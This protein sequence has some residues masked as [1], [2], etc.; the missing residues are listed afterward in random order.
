MHFH[1]QSNPLSHKAKVIN[2]T[3]ISF[4]RCLCSGGKGRMAREQ[5]DD[6]ICYEWSKIGHYA[7]TC[8]ATT[9]VFGLDRLCNTWI[10]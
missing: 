10:I 9:L 4:G 2:I 3:A 8:N 1:Q 6:V 5:R 7:T